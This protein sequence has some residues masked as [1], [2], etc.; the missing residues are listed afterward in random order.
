M[1]VRHAF[2]ITRFPSIACLLAHCF[3]LFRLRLRLLLPLVAASV[4]LHLPRDPLAS[5]L[6]FPS[7]GRHWWRL[8]LSAIIIVVAVAVVIIVAILQ[9][10]SAYCAIAVAW[11]VFSLS[12]THTQ[13]WLLLVYVLY[14]WWSQKFQALMDIDDVIICIIVRPLDWSSGYYCDG[15]LVLSLG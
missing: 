11:L 9:Q 4:Q 13:C 5:I 3:C 2:I 14:V 7:C 12:H 1:I 10:Q 6:L 15:Y 8:F